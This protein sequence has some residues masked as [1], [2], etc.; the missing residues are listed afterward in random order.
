MH[1]EKYVQRASLPTA[2]LA[3]EKHTLLNG[4]APHG[5]NWEG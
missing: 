1:P 2:R 4:T 5:A 3:M